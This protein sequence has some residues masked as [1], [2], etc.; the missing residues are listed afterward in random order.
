MKMTGLI[1]DALKS[2]PTD[3]RYRL[4]KIITENKDISFKEYSDMPYY[5]YFSVWNE[6]IIAQINSGEVV[7]HADLNDE[8][9]IEIFLQD[10]KYG[11]SEIYHYTESSTLGKNVY[12]YKTDSL[13]CIR[14]LHYDQII[15]MKRMA[16]FLSNDYGVDI[17]NDGKIVQ[18]FKYSGIFSEWEITIKDKEADSF[19][20]ILNIKYRYLRNDGSIDRYES[21]DFLPFNINYDNLY[22]CDYDE[23]MLKS[24]EIIKLLNNKYGGGE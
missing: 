2:Q 12:S 7:Y 11:D 14:M 3:D 20:F 15:M 16:K 19:A 21:F 10:S 13:L 6:S 1:A 17:G 8:W 24:D 5:L 18:E 9:S 22:F 4:P 23:F